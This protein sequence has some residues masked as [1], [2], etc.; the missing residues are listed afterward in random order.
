MKK[1]KIAIYCLSAL[2]LFGAVTSITS[3]NNNNTPVTPDPD[4]P[5]PNPD[6]FDPDEP[7]DPSPDKET[8]YHYDKWTSAQQE[9]LKKYCGD[10]LPFPVDAFSSNVIVE[11]IY[12]EEYD[13]YYLEIADAASS[14][15]LKDYYESLEN[16]GWNAITPYNGNKVQTDGTGSEFVELTKSSST[17]PSIGYDMLY[18][19]NS[20]YNVIHCYN[21]LTSASSSEKAWSAEDS[22]TIKETIV[23]ELPF[24]NLGSVNRVYQYNDN[25]LQI[26]DTYTTDLSKTYADL[27]IQ[28]GFKLSSTYSNDYNSWVLVKELEDGSQVVAQIYYLN[29]NGFYFTYAPHVEDYSEWPSEVTDEIKKLSG[30]E[31][32]QFETS[33]NGSFSAYRKNDTFY[34]YTESLSEDFDYDEYSYNQLKY[35]KLS[36]DETILVSDFN[37]TDD[38]YEVYGYGI[39]VTLTDPL[40]TFVESWPSNAINDT[41]S[42]LLN[43]KDANIPALDS[44]YT[45]LSDK[46][47]KYYVNGED[48][49]NAWYAYYYSYIKEYPYFY[50]LGDNPTEAEIEACAHNLAIKEMGIVI[51]FV[52]YDFVGN[53]AYEET[54]E[55]LGWYKGYDTWGYTYF[56]DPEGKVRITLKCVAYPS[57]DNEGQTDIVISVGSGETH[58]PEFMFESEEYSFAIGSEDNKLGLV[59]SMLPYDVTF[60]SSDETG[61]ISVDESGNVTIDESVEDGTTATITATINVPGE[62]EP[63]VIT[64]TVTAIKVTI[65]TPTSAIE[66]VASLMEEKGYHPTVINDEYTNKATIAFDSE[67]D[68]ESIKA[69][70]DSSF[71][72]EEFE[73]N[74][75]WC[76]A[77]IYP[78]DDT[79]VEGYMIN[80]SIWNDYCYIMLEFQIYTIDGVTYLTALAY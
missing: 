43:I 23:T 33:E 17:D 14:F 56:E 46:K 42:S 60:T 63:R 73:V 75:E 31:I 28:N 48:A 68:V 66:A 36:W 41:L 35:F 74:G 30:V 6:D 77:T 38:D 69:L 26:I 40:S 11:E 76:D 45:S 67:T 51:S 27:L 22:V 50:D 52:D 39:C 13:Y 2:A 54:L 19:Y 24:I 72:P 34:I 25:M 71:I 32:P 5:T 29:G 18:S 15:T 58:T 9:L 61:G 47:M 10:V 20:G 3:C 57:Y 70:V 79:E 55:N 44:T 53:N 78:D 80:Y 65:Y 37:L 7:I 59:K 21:D 12:D 16:L 62:E 64:C 49:Y 4:T 1:N 8:D